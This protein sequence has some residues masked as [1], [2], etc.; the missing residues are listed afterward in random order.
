MPIINGMKMACEPCIRG[1][2]ST[3]CTHASE[4]LMVPVKKPGRPLTACPH[5][6]PSS[7][8]CSSVTAAI[9]R[10]SQCGCGP[11]SKTAKTAVKTEPQPVDS[12]I[13]ESPS[14]VARD[15]KIKKTT[16]KT[17]SR[18]QSYDAS[19]LNR[20]DPNSVNV[21]PFTPR[22][23]QLIAPALPNEA[24]SAAP[25]APYTNG[26]QNHTYQQT[27]PPL[28]YNTDSPYVPVNGNGVYPGLNGNG[29]NHPFIPLDQLPGTMLSSRSNSTGSSYGTPANGVKLEN[30]T[31]ESEIPQSSC[32]SKPATSAPLDG[33][34][35]ANGTPLTTMPNY[36]YVPTYPLPAPLYPYPQPTLFAYPPSYGS[37]NN[38]LQPASWRQNIY[39]APPDI[40]LY[41]LQPDLNMAL[42]SCGC[43]PTCQCVGCAAHP[44]NDATQEYV[45]SA[46]AEPVSP[47]D[48]Y[49]VVYPPVFPGDD[50]ATVL[51]HGASA[52]E[53]PSEGGSMA[54]DQALSPSDF[55]FVSYPLSGEGC[56][57]D[58]TS[59][60]CGDGCQ[61]LGCTIHALD[62][63]GEAVGMA[64]G[65]GVVGP[66]VPVPAQVV[67]K[68][69][70][71]V[72]VPPVEGEKGEK[73]SCCCG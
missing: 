46:Y 23:Q 30:E 48:A 32:C 13:T 43:G 28:P 26:N 12:P 42:H 69:T 41:P 5:L 50:S 16:S 67:E 61:C 37:H 2:R 45:R 40:P 1:H 17:K 54:E 19:V 64:R 14:P 31:H 63:V 71:E 65:E 27:Q 36:T 47:P 39:A 66:T 24:K 51:E 56:G 8:G 68:E 18:K 52:K 15:F 11:G 58:T 55:F 3:K 57:G 34:I 73:K 25:L 72:E 4:R 9:P 70:V 20:V 21:V 29:V 22:P 33:M 10:K 44:Y 53:S 6:Q 38:P 49:G 60:P 35:F 7:C 62:E 59:C